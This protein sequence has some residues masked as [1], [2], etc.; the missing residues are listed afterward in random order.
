MTLTPLTNEQ[1]EPQRISWGWRTALSI[2]VLLLVAIIMFDFLPA[3][4]PVALS[5]SAGDDLF[6]LSQNEVL[7]YNGQ[8][9]AFINSTIHDRD[10]YPPP[11]PPP[12]RYG[13]FNGMTVGADHNIYATAPIALV[14]GQSD[15]QI[16]RFSAATGALLDTFIFSDKQPPDGQL[17][18]ASAIAFGP[19]GNLYVL[20]ANRIVRFNGKTGVFIGNVVALAR[21]PVA[22][23]FGPDRKLYISIRASGPDEV[24]RY[25]P[26]TGAFLGT[27]VAAGLGGLS[28]SSDLTFG[29]DGDL[30]I[31]NQ[32]SNQVLRYNGSTGAFIG[33]FVEQASAYPAPNETRPT[34]PSGLAFG[35]DGNL[36]V[37]S[38]PTNLIRRYDGTTGAPI[39]IFAQGSPLVNPTHL[40]FANASAITHRAVASAQVTLTQQTQPRLQ[41]APGDLVITTLSAHN[42]GAG[43]AKAI[44]V[45]M[46]FDPTAVVVVDATFSRP[47][48]WV[49]RVL[50]DALEIQL[51]DLGHD[52]VVTGTV[53]LRVLPGA[54]PG[55]PLAPRLSVSWHDAAGNGDATSNQPELVVGAT[56]I[57]A[58]AA[59][60]DVAPASGSASTVRTIQSAGFL[61]GEPVSLWYNTPDGRAVAIRQ[62]TASAAGAIQSTFAPSELP[63]GYYSLVAY[64]TWST[65]TVVGPWQ[66]E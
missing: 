64:G 6:V 66:I 14:N 65:I 48:A 43:S 13:Q 4:E 11:G 34:Y 17:R 55:A 35:P 15:A 3:R 53:R 16:V 57:D 61:P 27:F 12:F 7:H 47:S 62:V 46:P 8:T 23:V 38:F 41:A 21:Q 40:V 28:T 20:I 59:P 37:S 32:N 31:I 29:P 24:Q 9:G 18:N 51:G 22:F 50:S 39:G 25:D 42:R 63:P 33:V 26:N 52:S 56:A 10:S 54:A 58:P 19:D 60:L 45:K 1:T 30:Y 2:G 5:A 49:S 44:N 36:Y